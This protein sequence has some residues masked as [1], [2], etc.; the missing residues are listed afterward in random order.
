M[1]R[2]PC[3]EVTA[4]RNLI[5]ASLCTTLPSHSKTA[6]SARFSIDTLS[7]TSFDPGPP[8]LR[9]RAVPSN[10]SLR[11]VLGKRP[12]SRGTGSF[13]EMT[14]KICATTNA[15]FLAEAERYSPKESRK[16]RCDPQVTYPPPTAT[17]CHLGRVFIRQVNETVVQLTWQSR[18]RTSFPQCV[19]ALSGSGRLVDRV[20][21]F[22]VGGVHGS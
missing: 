1:I 11:F 17:N 6:R 22:L 9:A 2:A 10:C 5:S 13:G 18:T 15:V 16:N 14:E 7:I 3:C 21:N 4:P 8:A 12:S 19:L 20:S